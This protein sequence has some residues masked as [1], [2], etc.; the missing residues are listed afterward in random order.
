MKLIAI[1]SSPLNNNKRV[2]KIS[3]R[4]ERVSSQLNEDDETPL[5]QP[6]NYLNERKESLKHQL[7][8]SLV[9]MKHGI[10]KK[11]SYDHNFSPN[12]TTGDDLNPFK[13]TIIP[14]RELSQEV[15]VMNG[16]EL[17]IYIYFQ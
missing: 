13:L 14:L 10:E 3:N 1:D 9:F 11:E 5:S 8:N 7:S 6:F 16:F 15:S 2:S 4:D 17:D 12:I